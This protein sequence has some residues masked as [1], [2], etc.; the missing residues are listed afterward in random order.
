MPYAKRVADNVIKGVGSVLFVLKELTSS[1][2]T[3]TA[4]ALTTA[5]SRGDLLLEDWGLMTDATGLAGGT[6][7]RIQ[8]SGE[9]YGPNAIIEETVA[10][11]GANVAFNALSDEPGTA[12]ERVVIQVGDSLQYL[13]TGANC[14]GSGKILIWLKFRRI[15]HGATIKAV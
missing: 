10:N 5:V 1:D 4:A 7:F 3:T 9:T 13:S 11:L 8:V 2:I 12:S 6:N 14:T 15:A